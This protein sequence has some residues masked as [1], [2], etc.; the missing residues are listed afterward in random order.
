[1]KVTRTIRITSDAYEELFHLPCVTAVFR[2]VG[3]RISYVT[4]SP[5]ST[6]GRL[7]ALSGDYLVEFSS[8]EW[9]CFG[10]EAYQHLFK[11]PASKPWEKDGGSL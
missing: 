10:A 9:Q 1:M 11:N 7:R 2:E 6:R 8:G 3:K 5:E 4:L